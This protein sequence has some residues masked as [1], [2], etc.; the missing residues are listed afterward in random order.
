MRIDRTGRLDR[1]RGLL[2]TGFKADSASIDFA[3][4]V[5]SILRTFIFVH[6]SENVHYRT[7]MTEGRLIGLAL[8]SIENELTKID[9]FIDEVLEKFKNQGGINRRIAI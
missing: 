3:I 6:A 8:M 2:S 5:N 1:F 9:T 7:T 4:S